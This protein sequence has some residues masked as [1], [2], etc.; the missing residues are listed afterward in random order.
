[1]DTDPI[2][3]SKMFKIIKFDAI[4]SIEDILGQDQMEDINILV[5]H[6]M[7]KYEDAWI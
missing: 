7:D 3:R 5:E 2:K 6:I 4:E 1:M